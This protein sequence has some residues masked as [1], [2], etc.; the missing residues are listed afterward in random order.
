M[1]RIKSLYEDK[2][3]RRHQKMVEWVWANEAAE[4]GWLDDDHEKVEEYAAQLIADE[5]EASERGMFLATRETQGVSP[6]IAQEQ[7]EARR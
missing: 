1:S 7:W 5:D 4:M 2:Q 6:D 3:E